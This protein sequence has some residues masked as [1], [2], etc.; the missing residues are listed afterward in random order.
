MC[1]YATLVPRHEPQLL[2]L[3]VRLPRSH[4]TTHGAG[5]PGNMATCMQC[6]GH[7]CRLISNVCM[8]L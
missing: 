3:V 7:A 5:R 1:M 4:Y 2:S 6:N 8:T